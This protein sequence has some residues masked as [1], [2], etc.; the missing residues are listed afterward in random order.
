MCARQLRNQHVDIVSVQNFADYLLRIGN[1]N[2]QPMERTT[3]WITLPPQW[4]R[5][6]D[7]KTNLLI[8]RI[9][10]AQSND[11]QSLH[12]STRLYCKLTKGRRIHFQVTSG[13]FYQR[14]NLPWRR[15]RNL[16]SRIPEFFK[17]FEHAT[18]SAAPQTKST[19]N[20]YSQSVAG[21]GLMQR[22]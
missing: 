11:Q 22:Y 3:D 4:C 6:T 8:F 7:N 10:L 12:R 15:S 14:I 18:S 9:S 2:E 1:G 21:G 19:N 17:P 13:R 5:I 16:S 20:D